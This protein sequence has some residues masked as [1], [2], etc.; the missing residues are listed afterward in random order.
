MKKIIAILAVL[1]MSSTL[2]AFTS[3]DVYRL[4][5]QDREVTWGVV[6]YGISISAGQWVMLAST[7]N[8]GYDTAAV[9]TNDNSGYENSPLVYG[10]AEMSADS[11]SMIRIVTRGYT[12]AY[13]NGADTSTAAGIAQGAPLALSYVDGAAGSTTV[14]GGAG[15]ATSAAQAAGTK[16]CAVAMATVASTDTGLYNKYAVYVTCR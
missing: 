12:T 13:V 4:G 11:G 8:Q 14:T 5:K 2:F 16:V 10:V 6:A 9:V 1:A 3:E 15:V 7:D